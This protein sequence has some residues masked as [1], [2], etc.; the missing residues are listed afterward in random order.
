MEPLRK[1][2]LFMSGRRRLASP[3][4]WVGCAGPR[5]WGTGV[6]DD[7][8]AG[9]AADVC[10]WAVAAGMMKAKMAIASASARL[11][12]SRP[13]GDEVE[14]ERITRPIRPVASQVCI[15]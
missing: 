12:R 13:F 1:L 9:A 10:A 8:A 6:A 3:A 2:T 5:S 15:R 14:V 7:W 11:R 4:A